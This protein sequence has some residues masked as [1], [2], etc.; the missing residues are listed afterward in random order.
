MPWEIDYAITTFSQLNRSLYYLPEG[1][2]IKIRT[3]L[4][5][6]SW[7]ID[8][9]LSSI[10]KEYF[11]EK[12]NTLTSLLSRYD[13]EYTIYEGCDLYGH[14]D[15]QKEIYKLDT[16]YYLG[17][18][19]DIYFNEYLLSYML[20]AAQQVQNEYF[21]ITP[22][23]CTLWDPSWDIITNTNIGILSHSNW[24]DR[25]IFDIDHHLHNS[26]EV[27]ELKRLPSLKWAGWF[28]LY[29]KA[30]VEQLGDIPNDWS[31]YGAWDLYTM[32]V[33]GI[34]KQL[35]YDFDQYLLKGQIIF[36]YSHGV[37]PLKVPNDGLVGYY[38]NQLHRKQ[39]NQREAF[40]ANI[41]NYINNKVNKL[42]QK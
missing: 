21:Y 22:E 18:S 7:I 42:A 40:N 39:T 31:G 4:N 38:K 35:G 23:I 9:K 10:P 14:L 20:Q 8:W 33:C 19:P 24:I 11:I 26:R 27:V 29:N 32:N 17:I 37:G 6:S 25:D 30:F 41:H 28:D 1:H 2:T 12:Y 3:A 5:L 36:P 13:H 16:D 15:M 34:A